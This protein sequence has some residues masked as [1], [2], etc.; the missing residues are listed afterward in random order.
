M[1][2]SKVR[3]NRIEEPLLEVDVK[4][5]F[6]RVS[7]VVF[8]GQELHALLEIVGEAL[9]GDVETLKLVHGLNL[10]L[11]LDPGVLKSLVLDFD[12][13]D[14]FLDFLLPFRILNLSSLVIL[15]LKLP[16]FIEFKL[17]FD[18]QT[19]LIDRFAEEN[20]QNWLDFFVIVE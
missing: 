8:I 16:D 9:L 2:V 10:L 4:L 17:F 14:L 6:K 19:R 11:A 12:S 15:V 5:I 13:L 1:F 20:I 3:G 7:P 18:L